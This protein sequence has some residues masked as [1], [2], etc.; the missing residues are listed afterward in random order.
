MLPAG[1]RNFQSERNF[2][3]RW[4]TADDRVLY[5]VRVSNGKLERIMDLAG[6]LYLST[7][8][9][10]TPDD[11]PLMSRDVRQ[12]EIYALQVQW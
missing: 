11:S 7:W 5:R 9:G 6:L 3:C 10:L 8:L 1:T 4:R 12:I 2:R